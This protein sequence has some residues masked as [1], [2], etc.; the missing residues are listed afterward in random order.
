MAHD[1]G[2]GIVLVEF[3][4]QRENGMLLFLSASVG[5]AAFLIKSSFVADAQRT[6]VV[7]LG[8]SALDILGQDG[9]G[10]AIATNVVMVGGLAKAGFACGN[11]A[12]DCK[13]LIAA[14]AGAVNQEDLHIGMLQWFHHIGVF[15]TNLCRKIVRQLYR[16]QK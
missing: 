12:F 16:G 1:T 11:K 3:L 5:S 14:T 7:V 8:M 4:Q 15:R 6:V 13:R 9:D 10:V 2:I